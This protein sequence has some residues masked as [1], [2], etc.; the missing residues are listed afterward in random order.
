MTHY[1]RKSH[2]VYYHRY[3]IVWITKYR[4]KVLTYD[5]KKRVR[6]I[7]AQVATELGIKIENGV[8]SSDHIHIFAN[9]PPHIKI[10]EFV[11][12]AQGRSSKKMQ[13][14]FPILKQK[15]WGRHL[16]ARGYF[17]ATSGNVTDY[18]INEYINN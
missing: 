15:Y 10:C 4:Y 16:W 9:I 17:S 6:E 1:S 3:H 8:V 13:E 2:T 7:I 18:I 11:Q 14:E 5:I 12:K